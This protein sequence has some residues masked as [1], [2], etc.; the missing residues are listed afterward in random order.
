MP[1]EGVDKTAFWLVRPKWKSLKIPRQLTRLQ[2]FKTKFVYHFTC[3]KLYL[4]K[5][6]TARVHSDSTG[7]SPIHNL[8]QLIFGNNSES[9]C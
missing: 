7:Y 9:F 3:D 2:N 8:K 4:K 1:P 5:P 6:R